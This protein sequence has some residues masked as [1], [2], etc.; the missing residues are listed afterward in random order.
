MPTELQNEFLDDFAD[1][2]KLKTHDGLHDGSA[3]L[4]SVIINYKLIVA[5]I[6]K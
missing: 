3:A 2:L 4:E 5:V 1:V 6:K